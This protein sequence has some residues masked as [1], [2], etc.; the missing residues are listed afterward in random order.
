MVK[1]K[2]NVAVPNE[3]KTYT[4]EVDEPKSRILIGKK[5]GDAVD[6]KMLGLKWKKLMITGGTDSSGFP[7]RP[8]IHGGVKKR[9]LLSGGPGLKKI[10][11][12]GYRKKKMVRGN[13]ITTDIYQ[14]NMK[15]VE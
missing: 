2:L 11:R 7:M 12:K 9:V 3:G 6:G 14:I 13:V 4:F 5:I 10:K 1:F 8:D 15:V